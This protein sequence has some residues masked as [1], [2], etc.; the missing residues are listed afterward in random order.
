MNRSMTEPASQPRDGPPPPGP[1]PDV[2]VRMYRAMLE[3]RQFED[4]VFDL[5]AEG[6]VSGS[7]HLA[8]GQEAVAVGACFAVRPDDLMVCTYRGHHEC[9][10]KGMPLRTAMAEIL[11]RSTGCC[12]GKGGSMH[13]TDV[14][15]GAM[16]SFAIVGA[17]LPVACGL[18]WAAQHR[19]IDQ[20]TL[21][22]FGDGATNIGAFHEALNLAAVWKLPVVFV[23]ENNLYGEYS[24]IATTT[25]VADLAVRASAYAMEHRIVDGNDVEAVYQ[26]VAW[27]AA[28]ARDGAGPAF[29]EC[30]TYRQKGHSRGDPARYRPPGELEQWLAR[31]PIVLLRKRLL[32][33]GQLSEDDADK[34]AAEAE[35]AVREAE[36]AALDDPYPDDA[37]LAADVYAE[38][39]EP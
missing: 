10:A 26:D 31:D 39:I 11:G 12:G 24:P 14:S 21:C 22:F 3:I 18:A 38:A 2:L 27:A 15:I 9:L 29:L 33:G 36:Q 20:V 1:E 16:G 28:R 23:C 8:Q 4:R 5:F 34:I 25:P 19:G 17:G 35:T 6:K 37:S 32:E 30:K 13:L 7:T